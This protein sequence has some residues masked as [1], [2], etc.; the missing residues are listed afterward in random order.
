MTFRTRQGSNYGIC[1][2]RVSEPATADLGRNQAYF[3]PLQNYPPRA[4]FSAH[5]AG[6][7]FSADTVG[8]RFS[9]RAL[10]QSPDEISAE[11]GM[12][13][14]YK[15][16]CDWIGIFF[17]IFLYRERVNQRSRSLSNPYP[18]PMRK[19]DDLECKKDL[20]EVYFN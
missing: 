16:E 3:L 17:Q 1:R 7:R 2:G 8:M 4:D 20:L 9:P 13:E 5:V 6:N 14:K 19:E 18:K 10:N 15:V 12:D 11:A